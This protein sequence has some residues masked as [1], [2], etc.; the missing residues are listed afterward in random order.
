[1]GRYNPAGPIAQFIKQLKTGR[2][3]ALAGGKKISDA[4]MVSRGVTLLTQ[5]A[6][7]N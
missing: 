5:M 2:E 4:M 7:L 1:M 6:M 3:F